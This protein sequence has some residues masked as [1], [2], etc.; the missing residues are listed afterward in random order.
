MVNVSAGVQGIGTGNPGFALTAEKNFGMYSGGRLNVF[1]G[2]GWRTNEPHSH[3]IGGL[4][5]S[6]DGRFFLGVQHDG[7]ETHPFVTYARSG[8]IAGAYLINGKRVALMLGVRF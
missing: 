3:A 5:Y 4:K 8:W 2:M 6:P 7:H 1:A